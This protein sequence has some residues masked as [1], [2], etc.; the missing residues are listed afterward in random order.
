MIGPLVICESTPYK[1][2][3]TQEQGEREAMGKREL[4]ELR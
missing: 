3:C 4:L 1:Q 2:K